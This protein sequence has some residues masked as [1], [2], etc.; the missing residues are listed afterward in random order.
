[1]LAEVLS[2]FP[3][4]LSKELFVK[5]IN[6]YREIKIAHYVQ[7]HEQTLTKA[8]KFVEIVFQIL[9]Y[10]AF[11]EIPRNPNFKEISSKLEKEPSEK[12][13]ESLRVIIPRVAYTLY[14]IRSKR[15]AVHINDE[16]SPNFIDSTFVVASCNWILS[17]F[18]RIFLEKEHNEVLE[19]INGLSKVH[20]PLVEEISGELVVLRPEMTAKEQILILLFHKYP[21]FVSKK[22]LKRWVKGKSQSRVNC[23]LSELKKGS[24]IVEINGELKLTARGIEEAEKI[25]IRYYG[26]S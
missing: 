21:E 4:N 1:M 13:H 9:S 26:A 11:G 17:E 12:L 2:D 19:I 10:I 25:Q 14:T 3:S 15:G 6:E 22:E 23:A 8:G 18:L 16:V 7:N 20:L 24:L 5:L